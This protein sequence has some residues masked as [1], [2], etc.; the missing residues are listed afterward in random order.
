MSIKLK[1]DIDA[2]FVDF[3]RF[4][5]V[6]TERLR[7]AIEQ[8][9]Q[10][11]LLA[12][13]SRVRVR[14]GFAHGAFGPLAAR[15][16]VALPPG[17]PGSKPRNREFYYNKGSK[18]RKTP[19]AGRQFA[20][21]NPI[22]ETRGGA[23]FQ[24]DIDISYFFRNDVVGHSPGKSPWGAYKSGLNAFSR[25]FLQLSEEIFPDINDFVVRTKTNARF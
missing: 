13:A 12:A 21:R 7:A 3:P 5:R 4:K 15:L 2:T 19:T 25:V 14:T 20:S 9:A 16:G 23:R 22:R 11:F 24:Y 8:A 17:V 18:I 6:V 1:V 10:A